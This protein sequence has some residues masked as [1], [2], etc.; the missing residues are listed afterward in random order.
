VTSRRV[1]FLDF[2]GVLHPR[3]AHFELPNV[4]VARDELVAAGLLQHVPLLAELLAS[5]PD[6]TIV[7]HSSW[8][9][10]F[11]ARELRDLLGA[12]GPRLVG[13]TSGALDREASIL[14]YIAARQLQ[15]TAYRVLDDQPDSLARLSASTIRCDPEA[16]I[17]DPAAVRQLSAWL[18]SSSPDQMT[19]RERTNSRPGEP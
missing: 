7:V 15:P 18:A 16:G 2:D 11:T 13:S 12:L 10:L 5:H 1:L 19:Q 17:S 9:H 6:V 14:D 4:R 3:E 8:R